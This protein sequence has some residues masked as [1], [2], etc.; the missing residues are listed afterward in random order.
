MKKKNL[1]LLLGL[2]VLVLALMTV[3]VVGCGDNKNNNE[4]TGDIPFYSTDEEVFTIETPYCNL[5]YPTKWKDKIDVAG[6][7]HDDGYMV[8]FST[9]IEGQIIS[10]FDI[11]FE[12]EK[13]DLIGK[14]NSKEE[15]IEVYIVNYDIDSSSYSE[16]QKMEI[17]GMNNDINVIISK[18][19]E[20]YDFEL[21]Q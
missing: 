11:A 13:G 17:G 1:K 8:S 2:L 7:E 19:L 12:V 5:Q 16:D 6:V 10:L 18:L 3:L 20:Q 4:N 21:A 15:T 14:L 9:S